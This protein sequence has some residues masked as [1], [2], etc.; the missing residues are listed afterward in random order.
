[1]PPRQ[2]TTAIV[3]GDRV[4]LDAAMLRC[5]TY[6]HSWDEFYP[7]NLGTP[8]F[9]WRLSL[10]C[11]RCTAERHDLI[12][13]LGRVGQRQYV[14]PPN[15]SM[16]RDETPTRDELRQRMLTEVRAKLLA[17]QAINSQV[18]EKSA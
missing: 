3:G 9:G 6:G 8:S 14:Y 10:R 1:M 18:M 5:R 15:Y 13:V 4:G 12:D 11:A 17:A 7:P 16:L 2:R